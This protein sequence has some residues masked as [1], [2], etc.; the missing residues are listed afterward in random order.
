MYPDNSMFRHAAL[1]PPS[2]KGSVG[3][4]RPNDYDVYQPPFLARTPEE[5]RR[6]RRA[7][8]SAVENTANIAFARYENAVNK[9][10]HVA[11]PEELSYT[12]W[13]LQVG[14]VLNAHRSRMAKP[15]D[16]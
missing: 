13:I 5:A 3:V 16:K 9:Q 10:K 15:E 2:R 6:A 1:V 14:E 4:S 11:S 12:R 7:P 8:V